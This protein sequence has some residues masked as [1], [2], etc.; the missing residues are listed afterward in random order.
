M[1]GARDAGS[2]KSHTGIVLLGGGRE[3]GK[4]GAKIVIY[5]G[6]TKPMYKQFFGDIYPSSLCFLSIV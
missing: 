6:I 4:E 1:F 5:P 3:G 2:I